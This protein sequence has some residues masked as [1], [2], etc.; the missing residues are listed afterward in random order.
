MSLSSYHR[1]HD[2]I[3]FSIA[4]LAFPVLIFFL[5]YFRW[6]FAWFFVGCL[7]VGGYFSFLNRSEK[8]F[9][10][11]L[12]LRNI[13]SIHIVL[14]I[15]LLLI[16]WGILVL[17]GVGGY[18]YQTEDWLK[19]NA[20]L[21]ALIQQ[22]W[23]VGYTIASLNG[24]EIHVP[25]VYYIAYY[26]P[27]ALIGKMFGWFWANQALFLWTY[28][29][30]CLALGWFVL[31]VRRFTILTLLLFVSFSGLDALGIIL[32]R[33]LLLQQPIYFSQWT[34]IER[35]SGNWQYPANMTLLFWVPNQAL[36]G[37]I[38]AGVL[39]YMLLYVESSKKY[40]IFFLSLTPLWSPFVTLGLLPY[41]LV[42]FFTPKKPFSKRITGYVSVSNMCGICILLILGLFYG[43]KFYELP[44]N[45]SPIASGIIFFNPIVSGLFW[46]ESLGLF[47]VFLLLEFGVYAWLIYQ[48]RISFDT[49]EKL[50]L[51]T[52][53]IV[54]ALLPFFRYGFWN[55]LVMRASIVPLFIFCIFI[56]RTLYHP[57]VRKGVLL[58]LV[59]ALMVGAVNTVVGSK[60]HI[61][62][63][64]RQRNSLRLEDPKPLY[65]LPNMSINPSFFTQYIGSAESPFFRVFAKPLKASDVVLDSSNMMKPLSN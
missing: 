48:S 21:H 28:I 51:L 22:P 20:V 12:R 10:S 54:L 34:H 5:G 65:Q 64:Y 44:L 62:K 7:I 24:T 14:I 27:A 59:L 16:A 6:Y 60:L 37:W 4:Y 49:R 53:V 15:F 33:T 40:F 52:T 36:V 2:L 17:S 39:C 19:H 55:D 46:Y 23:P 3:I 47:F 43:A 18:G 41:I 56:G 61:S 42:D 13:S 57:S 1:A 11:L 45:V 9:V 50:L 29:G 58:F 32:I 30:I 38:M 63:I 26:L 35:W 25:L 8:I 31:L